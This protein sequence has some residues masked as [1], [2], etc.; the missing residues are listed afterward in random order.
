MKACRKAFP[1]SLSESYPKVYRLKGILTI[2]LPTEQHDT[3]NQNVVFAKETLQ[4]IK[5][6][7]LV[8]KG[9]KESVF[10]LHE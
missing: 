3:L 2:I 5:F 8:L 1:Q 6:E 7:I 9:W 4:I 10:I